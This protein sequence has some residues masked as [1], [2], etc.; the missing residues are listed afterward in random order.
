MV[1]AVAFA[2]IL[3]FLP[4]YGA[5]TSS[6]IGTLKIGGDSSGWQTF[7]NSRWLWLL[8]I[9]VAL[10]SVAV[11]ARERRRESS[12]EPGVIVTGLGGLSSLF[13][14][15]R[16]IDHPTGGATA[17]VG[18]SHLSY[19]YGIKIGIWLALLAALAVAAGGYLQ[20]RTEG[21][22]REPEKGRANDAFF[23]LVTVGADGV[24]EAQSSPPE[25]SS[26]RASESPAP[27]APTPA[28]VWMGTA[29]APVAPAIAVA[30]PVAAPVMAAAPTAAPVT[31]PA[32]ARPAAPPSAAPV[33]AT[34]GAPDPVTAAPPIPPPAAPPIPPPAIVPVVGSPL[35]D[36]LPAQDR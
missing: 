2:A 27:G 5:T 22:V 21:G 13:I 18:L 28:E 34:A 29:P 14:L 25:L 19:S 35:E 9:I 24:S 6:P 16:I 11:E 17:V 33:P 7:T 8:T 32:P 36:S 4:W 12:L 30:T 10:G 1:G 26:P 15:Y 3:F 23:G 20:M 31:P